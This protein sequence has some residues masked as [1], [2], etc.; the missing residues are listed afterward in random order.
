MYLHYRYVSPLFVA[1]IPWPSIG[2]DL[3]NLHSSLHKLSSLV[4]DGY[5]N[6]TDILNEIL[7]YAAVERSSDEALARLR[8]LGK[9]LIDLT[10]GS[11]SCSLTQLAARAFVS[12]TFQGGTFESFSTSDV[13]ALVK[14][15]RLPRV[16]VTHFQ[17]V[18]LRE[19]IFGSLAE[20]N[21]DEWSMEEFSEDSMDESD[22]EYW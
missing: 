1:L 5:F 15:L 11:L 7:E 2:R 13:L 4:D 20:S 17:V 3:D 9:A 16:C 22:C 12:A 8:R 10:F 14:R 19:K 6:T 18:L 21:W